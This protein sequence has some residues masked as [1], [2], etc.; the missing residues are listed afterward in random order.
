ME[1]LLSLMSALSL[2]PLLI[3]NSVRTNQEGFGESDFLPAVFE[4]GVFYDD[5]KKTF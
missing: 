5:K 1:G 3:Q 2:T 4:W